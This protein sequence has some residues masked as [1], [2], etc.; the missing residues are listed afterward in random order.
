MPG[1]AEAL[2]PLDGPEPGVKGPEIVTPVGFEPGF[3]MVRRREMEE[4]KLDK[5]LEDDLA[6]ERFTGD[7]A[8]GDTGLGTTTG[9]TVGVVDSGTLCC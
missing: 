8:T 9:V 7:G 6:R 1:A 3:V 2:F 5:R 4:A